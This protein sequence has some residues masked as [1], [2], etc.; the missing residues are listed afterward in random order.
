MLNIGF[1]M[2]CLVVVIGFGY[3]VHM[4]A[5]GWGHPY[6]QR[7]HDSDGQAF[8]W[9]VGMIIFGAAACDL[10]FNNGGFLHALTSQ[11]H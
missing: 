11:H 8:V 2:L 9:I 6:R 4:E 7:S 10:L 1:G 5:T 3:G